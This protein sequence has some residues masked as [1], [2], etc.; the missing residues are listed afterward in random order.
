[1]IRAFTILGAIWV[2]R[3]LHL[4]QIG[5][6]GVFDREVIELVSKGSEDYGTK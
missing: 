1:M 5:E 6:G 3:F 4:F 2:P